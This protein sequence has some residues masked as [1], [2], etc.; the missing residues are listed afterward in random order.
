MISPFG[1]STVLPDA[2]WHS[3][4]RHRGTF[5]IL[6]SC[7]ITMA[8][9]I[10][11][12]VH[13]NLP[14]HRKE[15]QQVY[16]KALWLTLGLFA[17]E[18]VVWN[19]WA[20]RQRMKMLS[21]QM[22]RMGYMAEETHTWETVRDW[23][24]RAS[25]RIQVFLLLRAEDWP[26]PAVH[27]K[28]RQLCHS[29]IHSWTD[30][31]SWYIIMGGL[32]FEDTAVEELQFMPGDRQ[33]LI[34]TDQAVLYVAKHRPRLLPDISRQHIGDKSKSGGLGKF[35]TCWQATYFCAQCVFRLSRQYSIS[36]LEL[37][38]FAH[39]VC[40]LLLFWLWWDKPQDVH[41][42]TLITDSDGLDL[43]AYFSIRPER[44]HW[45]PKY[46]LKDDFTPCGPRTRWI[47]CQPC[48]DAWEVVKPRAVTIYCQHTRREDNPV[49]LYF[50][51]EDP[52]RDQRLGYRQLSF[53][54]HRRPCLNVLDTFWTI[55]A[56]WG[57][58]GQDWYIC[59]LDSRCIRRLA[60]AYG[61]VIRNEEYSGTASVVDRC[62][63][64]ERDELQLLSN[65]MRN[66]HFW[67]F[68]SAPVLP[69][70]ERA[71]RI[72][73][74]YRMMFRV[75]AGLTLAG[76]C[77]GGLHLTAWTCQ[78]PSHAET[79]LW[80]AA[81]VTITATGP[82]VFAFALCKV[83]ASI[84]I[85]RFVRICPR[86]RARLLRCLTDRALTVLDPGVESLAKPIFALFATWYIL[87]RAFIVVECFIMLAHLPDTTLEIPRWAAYIPHIT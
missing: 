4:P 59:E 30:V 49:S 25:A 15:S 83:V 57:V 54:P 44:I 6:S 37:N 38:V 50:Q 67:F 55:E 73:A 87:C 16:R 29:R 11:T 42:P 66:A 71:G 58:L 79:L 8:L 68:P 5:S 72:A 33:R 85:T 82:S 26:K 63:D 20:Q 27:S 18:V 19:A 64:F 23:C 41:E 52:D 65:M 84:F 2:A 47:P 45:L 70:P 61:N 80:R 36:L 7:L 46:G 86:P 1:N 13:L 39:A 43:C 48:S 22:R 35:L 14:E 9:C 31:H 62:V 10:W 74:Q 17:P 60:R 28:R 53:G 77:Y 56:A 32:A 69:V 81:G 51:E 3:E 75:F 40:A 34:L 21:D 12:A 78:F 76:G 24:H